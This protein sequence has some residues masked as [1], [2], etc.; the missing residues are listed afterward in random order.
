MDL[1]LSSPLIKQEVL[2][3]LQIGLLCVQDHPDDRLMMS[4]VR[5]MIGSDATISQTKTS[6]Y[7]AHCIGKRSFEIGS[8][9]TNQSWTTNQVALSVMTHD[10]V[11]TTI[12]FL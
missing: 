1:T 8:S 9:S 3:L 5:M 10:D 12:V 4:S 6:G 11:S 2:R 7:C